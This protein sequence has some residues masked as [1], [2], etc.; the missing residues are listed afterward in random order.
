MEKRDFVIRICIA[1]AIFIIIILILAVFFVPWEQTNES[2]S[3]YLLTNTEYHPIWWNMNSNSVDYAVWDIDRN[4]LLTRSVI[5]TIFYVLAVMFIYVK[6][7]W[8]I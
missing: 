5:V 1:T 7:K 2:E 4:K 8:E 3:P 6:Y